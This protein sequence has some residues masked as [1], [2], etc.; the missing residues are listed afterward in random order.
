MFKGATA[1]EMQ[2]GNV[3]FKIIH[4]RGG[5]WTWRWLLKRFSCGIDRTKTFEEDQNG[6]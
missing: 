5:R 3:Y 4:L 2:I 6:Q 1:Y